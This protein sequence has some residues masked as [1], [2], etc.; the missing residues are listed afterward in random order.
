M[1]QQ[2]RQIS[3]SSLVYWPAKVLLHYVSA[4][5]QYPLSVTTSMTMKELHSVQSL[6]TLP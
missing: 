1:A 6:I 2:L 4:C 3:M 5:C